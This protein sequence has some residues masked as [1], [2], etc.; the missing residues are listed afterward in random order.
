V[1]AGAVP[2][3]LDAKVLEKKRLPA[4]VDPERLRALM[5]QLS[6]DEDTISAAEREELDPAWSRTHAAPPVPME[7]WP[8]DEEGVFAQFLAW[9]SLPRD[10]S[11]QG[12]IQFQGWL[13]IGYL[14]H[15]SSG[16]VVI[17]Q[18]A[19]EPAG[20]SGP[21][22]DVTGTLL[23]SFRPDELIARAKAQLIDTPGALDVAERLGLA[24]PSAEERRRTEEAAVA[25]GKDE[26]RRGRRGYPESHYR[27]VALDHLELLESGMTRGL[28][29]ELGN[30]YGVSAER[31]R[32]WVQRASELEFLTGGEKQGR[33]GRQAGPRLYEALGR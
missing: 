25:A 24:S 15:A 4:Q 23:R 1:Y 10:R 16:R 7:V 33:A 18:L 19:L 20:D 26:R 12:R 13:A 9:L 6:L 2:G 21:D 28:H 3:P 31:M 32:D 30:R 5:Q 17:K 29:K 11:P 27:R 14:G 8:V 22:L